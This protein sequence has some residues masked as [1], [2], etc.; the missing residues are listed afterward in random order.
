MTHYTRAPASIV[1]RGL[2]VNVQM[3]GYSVGGSEEWFSGPETG[4]ASRDS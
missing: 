3:V 1:P 4:F 2:T